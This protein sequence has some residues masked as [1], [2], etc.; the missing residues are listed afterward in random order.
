MSVF[1]GSD[2]CLHRAWLN[3][4]DGKLKASPVDTKCLLI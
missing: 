3:G 1:Q 4:M 2:G